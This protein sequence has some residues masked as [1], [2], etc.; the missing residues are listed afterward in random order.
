MNEVALRLAIV[1]GVVLLSAVIVVVMRRR[2]VISAM[3]RGG[4]GPGVYLFT[5]SSCSDCAGARARLG[6]VLGS[7]A[8]IEISWEDDAGL[9]TQLGIDAVPCTVVVGD[10]GSALV[11][12]GMPDRALR[13]L[14][15]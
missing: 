10:D 6:E 7:S 3:D 9:F 14:N 11:Y 1:V 8:F 2:P 5:S 13:S 4:L 15:P 12:P